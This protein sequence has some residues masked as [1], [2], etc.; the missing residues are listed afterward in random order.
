MVGPPRQLRTL[1]ATS[2]IADA[3]RDFPLTLPQQSWGTLSSLTLPQ[4]SCG[5]LPLPQGESLIADAEREF[6]SPSRSK[7]AGRFPP[8][9]SRSFAA[10]R[11][12]PSPS[13]SKAAGRFPPSPSRSFAAGPSLSHK[14]RGPLD[15]RDAGE[16]M[17]S[18]SQRYN[19]EGAPLRDTP[20][21]GGGESHPLPLRERAG[22]R[23]TETVNDLLG[24]YG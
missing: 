9:P 17:A 24:N 12:P 18:A 22:V 3:E 1:F 20:G 16:A 23:G 14:G 11:F 21:R 8:S 10:G 6:P 5:S 19:G 4:Q 15:R 2:G 7:A 13:R